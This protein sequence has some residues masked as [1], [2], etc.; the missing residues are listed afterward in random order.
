MPYILRVYVCHAGMNQY[1]PASFR[2]QSSY[3]AWPSHSEFELYGLQIHLYCNM[4]NG[5]SSHMNDMPQQEL[6][7]RKRQI[8]KMMMRMMMTGEMILEDSRKQ[9][10][11]SQALRQQSLL[12]RPLRLRHF[13]RMRM[14]QRWP[15]CSAHPMRSSSSW[16][17]C[18]QSAFQTMQ[19]EH[20]LS[21]LSHMTIEHWR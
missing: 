18:L 10:R 7:Q 2:A 16:Y 17:A 4:L 9:Q 5:L 6:H 12:L 21:L 3:I 13:Q 11:S 1:K 15:C 8:M 20:K 19:A 14:S